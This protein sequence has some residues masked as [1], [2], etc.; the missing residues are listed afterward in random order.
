MTNMER[1]LKRVNEIHPEVE[2]EEQLRKYLSFMTDENRKVFEAKWG[3]DRLGTYCD[4]YKELNEKL[5]IRNSRRLYHTALSEFDFLVFKFSYVS[6]ITNYEE[7]IE[8][9]F[10]YGS[11][12]ALACKNYAHPEKLPP[13]HADLF[14]IKQRCKKALSFFT[15]LERE[16]FITKYGLNDAIWCK[17]DKKV[18]DSLGLSFEKF[19]KTFNRASKKLNYSKI[20][21]ILL[22]N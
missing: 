10:C 4:T 11:F 8:L 15:K 12:I 7:D 16:I 6:L 20:N 9:A 13:L 21:S 22:G 5:N 19:L 1:C 14:E 3:I 18:L 2:T 17:S